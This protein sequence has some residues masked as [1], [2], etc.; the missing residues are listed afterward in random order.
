MKENG[1]EVSGVE[2][3]KEAYKEEF[4]KRLSNRKPAPGWEKFVEETNVAIRK[5]IRGDSRS[6][7][8]FTLK[9]LKAIVARLKNNKC[10]GVDGFPAE[11]FKNAG[12]G[13]LKSLLSIFNKVKKSKEIPEQWNSV[14]IA[15]IL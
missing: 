4:E 15:G 10:P 1:I 3:V 6:S 5:W 9:E 13:V 14:R 2:G 11:L 12:D 8:A 7:R